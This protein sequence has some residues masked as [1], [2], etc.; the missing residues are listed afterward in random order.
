[1]ITIAGGVG[2]LETRLFRTVKAP[3]G[4]HQ[5]TATRFSAYRELQ[6]QND[7]ISDINNRLF[8]IFRV[9]ASV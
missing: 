7:I 9:G 4:R 8:I 2:L 3:S 1:M 5:R 6:Y